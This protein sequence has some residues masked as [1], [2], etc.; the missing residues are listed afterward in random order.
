M[1]VPD[2]VA[3]AMVTP[4]MPRRRRHVRVVVVGNVVAMATGRR[5]LAAVLMRLYVFA[6][7]V[8]AHE[9][10]RA[11]GADESFLASVSSDMSLQFVAAGEALATEQ[12]VA[13]ERPFAGVPA[14][15]RLQVRSLVVH[16]AAAG[17]VAAVHAA[18]AEVQSGGRA[19][20]VRLLAVGAVARAAAGVAPVRPRPRAAAAGARRPARPEPRHGRRRRRQKTGRKNRLVAV[21]S[22]EGR[23]DE[24]RAVEGLERRRVVGGGGR[25]VAGGEAVEDCRRA[26]VVVVVVVVL[27]LDPTGSRCRVGAAPP[28]RHV[29]YVGRN[30]LLYAYRNNSGN[31]KLNQRVRDT[32]SL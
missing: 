15:V 1:G 14:Q 25:M 24:R 28:S 5:L 21:G 10:L 22:H 26:A 11:D 2:D 31:R 12:P 7:V 18:F 16:L 19:E 13:E 17:Q 9:P 20:P 3:V 27:L 30:L 6:E 32:L 4:A 23:R 29:R 8:G